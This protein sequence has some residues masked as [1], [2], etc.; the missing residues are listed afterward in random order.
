[1]PTGLRP[2]LRDET[3]LA[4]RAG[5]KPRVI[6]ANT[7]IQEATSLAEYHALGSDAGAPTRAAASWP[8]DTRFR[9]HDKFRLANQH[10]SR[11]FLVRSPCDEPTQGPRDVAPGLL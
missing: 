10:A 8:L 2:T 7:R 1:M 3:G 9:S 6:L 5:R 4:K 11:L